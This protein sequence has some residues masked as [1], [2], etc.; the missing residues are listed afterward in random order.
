MKAILLAAGSG[1]RMRP[2]TSYISKHLMPIAEKPMIYYSLSTLL[3]AGYREINIIVNN[4]DLSVYQTLLGDGSRLGISL[5][6]TVQSNANGIAEAFLLSERFIGDSNVALI[7]GDNVFFGP[8]LTDHLDSATQQLIGAKIMVYQTNRPSDFGIAELNQFNNVISIE[9]K[10]I[11]PKSNWAVTGL[12]FY[13]NSVIKRARDVKPSKRGELEITDINQSYLTDGQLSVEK[14][15]RG[16][17]WIDAGTH[18]NLR[19]IDNTIYTIET[20]QGY[21]IGCLEEIA[22]RNGW[23]TGQ[24]VEA[25]IPIYGKTDYAEYLRKLL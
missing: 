15:G 6:Y 20:N 18:A 25:C 13:D 7:L 9:E 21:K 22:L 11:F 12:Y 14:L 4:D 17:S 3:L 2:F 1:T 8:S 5:S 16:F 23:I 10:P 24:E 19:A